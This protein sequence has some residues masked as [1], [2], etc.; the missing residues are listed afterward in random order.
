M[1]TTGCVFQI[2]H[3]LIRRVYVN[4]AHDVSRLSDNSN[5]RNQTNKTRD[6]MDNDKIGILLDEAY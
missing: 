3:I 4:Y 5:Q 6:H 2:T 1:H